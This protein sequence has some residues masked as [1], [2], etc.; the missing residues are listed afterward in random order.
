MTCEIFQEFLVSLDRRMASKGRKILLFVDH[1]P[2]HPKD[3]RNFKNV[4]VEFFP[5]NTTSVLHP[6]DQGIIKAL[7][8]KFCRSFVLRLLQRHNS[9]KDSYKISLLDA[10]SMLAMAWNLVGKDII[11]N[12]FRKAGFI[13]NAEPAV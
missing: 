6:M 7:K 4:Q 12:C 5:A 1:C 3:A 9:N 13:T 11:A 2:A 8:Q 10:V